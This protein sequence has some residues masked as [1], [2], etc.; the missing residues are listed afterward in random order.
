MAGAENFFDDAYEQG[1]HLQHWDTRS[2]SAELLALVASGVICAGMRVLDI[3]CGAGREA[4]YLGKTG[5]VVTGIDFSE[6]GLQLARQRAADEGVEVK[7]VQASA[8]EVPV[9]DASIEF[10]NDRGCLHHIPEDK[11]GQYASEVGRVLRAGGVFF[12]RGARDANGKQF[13]AITEES[14]IRNFPA[15]EWEHGVMVE[16]ASMSEQKVLPAMMAMLRKR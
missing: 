11:R 2:A 5:C 16:M 1:F 13:V 9:D 7:F 15:E 12:V 3:G 8:L 10:V 4:I 6:A 14:L